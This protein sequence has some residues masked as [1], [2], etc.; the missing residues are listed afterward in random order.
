MFTIHEISKRN[1]RPVWQN[2]STYEPL[3]T[4]N[5]DRVLWWMSTLL[6]RTMVSLISNQKIHV[7]HSEYCNTLPQ[8][9][10]VGLLVIENNNYT[11][12]KARKQNIQGNPNQIQTNCKHFTITRNQALEYTLKMQQILQKLQVIRNNYTCVSL[13]WM[14][15]LISMVL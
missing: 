15:V 13:W 11:C 1:M 12:T 3:C 5:R 8:R 4:C 7:F 10:A 9:V 14:S 6:N 2:G